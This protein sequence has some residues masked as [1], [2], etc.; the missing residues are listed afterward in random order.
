[1]KHTFLLRSL[2]FA[3]QKNQKSFFDNVSCSIHE[4]GLIFI[5]GKNG[6]GKST[7]FRILQGLTHLSE[8]ITGFLQLSNTV[9]D[10]SG[11]ADREQL[12]NK[13]M[14]LHQNFDHMIVPSFT[15]FENL[16]YAQ[17]NNYPTLSTVVIRDD[18]AKLA[19][20]FGIPLDKPVGLLS[21]GQRQMLALLMVVQ[22]DI[23]LLLLDEPTSALDAINSK[24]M[25]QGIQELIKQ[26][27]MVVMC[28]SHDSALIAE[29]GD[30]VLT[31][32]IDEKNNRILNLQR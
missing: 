17:F 12:Q 29:Y 13:S 27:D 31:I 23:E 15:G 11:R 16:R 19:K 28:I 32:M 25:M 1:M 20:Q 26:K 24:I 3:F 7:L 22:R 14:L 9:Y 10:L 5:A 4:P 21:G 18:V 2:S 30:H 6:I 8:E